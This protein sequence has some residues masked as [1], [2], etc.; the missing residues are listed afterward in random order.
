MQ[1]QPAKQPEGSRP[2]RTATPQIKE[3]LTDPLRRLETA[4]DTPPVPGEL[5]NWAAML[6]KTF[7]ETSAEILRQI[8]TVHADQFREIEEQNAELLARVKVCAKKT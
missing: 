4:L 5:R 2:P 1:K 3:P 6:R 8:D 7:D